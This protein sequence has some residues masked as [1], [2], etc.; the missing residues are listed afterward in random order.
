M[1]DRVGHISGER[2]TARFG[3][4]SAVGLVILVLAGTLFPADSLATPYFQDLGRYAARGIN[5][6]GGGASPPFDLIEAAPAPDGSRTAGIAVDTL[7]SVEIRFAGYAEHQSTY[8][9]TTSSGAFVLDRPAV[10]RLL[11]NVTVLETGGSPSAFQFRITRS[12]LSTVYASDLVFNGSYDFEE[13]LDLAPGD[14]FFHIGA[15]GTD[16]GDGIEFDLV[17]VIPEPS[18]AVLL[19]L[20]L[21]VLA[22]NENQGRTHRR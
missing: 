8:S 16:G 20:G 21:A 22:C 17:L 19:G 13:S 1:A 7:S 18:I 10:V 14:F 2:V 12:P 6:S 5:E 4:E 15:I 9:G 11:G 3:W